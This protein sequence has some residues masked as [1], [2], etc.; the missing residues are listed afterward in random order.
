MSAEF[1]LAVVAVG[2]AVAVTLAAIALFPRRYTERVLI[3][4]VKNTL[5]RV[6]FRRK[7]ARWGDV[8]PCDVRECSLFPAAPIDCEK[9]CMRVA[10]SW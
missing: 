3:C 5:A 8:E 10:R 7:E 1:L 2:A 9:S 4:P 6:V